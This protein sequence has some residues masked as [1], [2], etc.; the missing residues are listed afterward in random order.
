MGIKIGGI[1]IS[2][3]ISTEIGPLL[4]TVKLVKLKAGTRSTASPST[5]VNPSRRTYITKGLVTNYLDKEI[6][7]KTIQR[8]DRKMLM[9]GDRFPGGIVP[10]PG[11]EAEAEGIK[12]RIISVRRDP[13]AATYT[14]Q[15][16]GG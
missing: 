12:F 1:N 4:Q 10:N 7:D 3:I 9:I 14:C 6:D 2:G 5:G 11:D 13:A 16:R 15:V 8:E